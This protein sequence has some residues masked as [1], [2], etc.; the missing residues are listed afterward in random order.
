VSIQ[1]RGPGLLTTLQDL[2]RHG[3]Q[4]LGIGPGGAMD[5]L[6]HR[7]ASLLVGNPPELPSMEITL[8]GPELEFETDSLVALAGADLSA[9][10]DGLP[11]PLW[12]PVLVRAGARMRFG[13]AVDGCRCY[14]AVAGGFGVPTVLGGAGTHLI[15]GFGG[16][17]GRPL[18]TGDRLDTGPPPPDRYPGLQRCFRQE[19]RALQ[20]LGWFVPWF[21][22]LDFRRPAQLR[23]IPGPHWPLLRPEARAS[24]LGEPFRVGSDSDRMGLRLGGPS[25]DLD[26]PLEP[27]SAGVA[28]G[29]L[30]L[31]PDGV[32]IL[33]MADRQT[34][35]GYPRLGELASV[36]LPRAGQ[37]RPGDLLRFRLITLE[38]AQDQSLERAA[39]LAQLAVGVAERML[40]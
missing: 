40:R 16:F 38:E 21:Q 8:C 10:V 29:T 1:V 4:H 5:E 13:A 25:L 12:R 22:E 35:G 39:R 32:P 24:L 26:R 15:A 20:S 17:Q 28:T 27:V 7:L 33:L 14:L 18:R 23:L 6:S 19:T 34:T 36:D 9:E 30:Q 2:G 37:L 11:V 31:P 3:R